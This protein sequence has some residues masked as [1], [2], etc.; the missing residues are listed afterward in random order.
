MRGRGGNDPKRVPLKAVMMAATME[1]AT[2]AN[3]VQNPV[4]DDIQLR[5]AFAA[6]QRADS[7]HGNAANT[8]R[9]ASGESHWHKAVPRF[10]I[11]DSFG[12]VCEIP[13]HSQS[14]CNPV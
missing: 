14:G 5:Q 3:S 2:A 12:H 13:N 8:K 6:A 4:M 9:S 1:N 7:G 11:Y 10:A